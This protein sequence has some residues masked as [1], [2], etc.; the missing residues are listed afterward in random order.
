M[1]SYG[2]VCLI[3]VN[4]IPCMA[5]QVHDILVGRGNQEGVGNRQKQPVLTKFRHECILLSRLR[6]PNIVQFIGVIYGK[7]DLDLTLVMECLHIDLEK[8]LK[9]CPNITLALKISILLDVSYGLLHLHSQT[10]PIIH[11]DLTPANILLTEGMQAKIAD[12]GVSKILDFQQMKRLTIHPGAFAYMPPEAFESDYGKELDCFSFGA[13]AL[14]T[15]NQQFPEVD[16]DSISV[17]SAQDQ[18]IQIQKR[19]KWVEMIGKDHCL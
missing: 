16:D 17:Q 4:G 3:E 10:P 8:C 6:H 14:Y 19:I 9:T 5:K 12:F 1:G 15:V 7:D 2:S 11:R 18:D 13:L